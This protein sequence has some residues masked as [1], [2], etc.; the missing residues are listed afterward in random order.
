M[1]LV[2]WSD[3]GSSSLSPLD[4]GFDVTFIQRHAEVLYTK[5][6]CFLEIQTA[7]SAH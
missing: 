5:T 1:Q 3:Y 4:G 7:L 6:P 2:L